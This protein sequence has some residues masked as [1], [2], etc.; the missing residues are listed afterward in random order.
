MP[1]PAHA[2]VEKSW[3]I[4]SDL[5]AA[6]QLVADVAIFLEGHGWSQESVFAVHMA[7]DEALTNAV[8]HGNCCQSGKRIWVDLSL[9]DEDVE[10]SVRDEGCGFDPD[11]IPD[12]TAP[13]HLESVHGRGVLI[14]RSYMDEVHYN[15]KGNCIVMRRMRNRKGVAR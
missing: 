13:E 9:S 1:A 10:L 5:A 3:E 15:R 8:K 2:T 7:M 6:H 4:A 14:I 12:P 11:H